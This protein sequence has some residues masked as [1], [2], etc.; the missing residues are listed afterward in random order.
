MGLIEI[1]HRGE[2]TV[3]TE[4]WLACTRQSRDHT[5]LAIDTTNRMIGHVG[6]V[7]IPFCIKTKLMRQVQLSC[8]CGT[9]ITS[10]PCLASRPRDGCDD[11]RLQI[12]PPNDVAGVLTNVQRSIRTDFESKR[13]PE[14]RLQSRPAI[15]GVFVLAVSGDRH[16]FCCV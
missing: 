1:R 14:P 5:R 3:P 12:H 7:V 15:A 4:A 8:R 2:A 10:E 13:L 6:N 11:V 9:S 16:D